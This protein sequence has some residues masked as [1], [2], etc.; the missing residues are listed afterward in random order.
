MKNQLSRQQLIDAV[1]SLRASELRESVAT[2]RPFY[3]DTYTVCEPWL[4]CR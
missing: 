3:A 4:V 1:R 2:T